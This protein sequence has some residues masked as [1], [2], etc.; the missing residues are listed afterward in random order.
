L[1]SFPARVGPVLPR[2]ARSLPDVPHP[3]LFAEAAAGSD[4]MLAA[5]LAAKHAA[6]N[7]AVRLL[8]CGFI[9]DSASS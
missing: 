5:R 9:S 1:F 2:F 4:A 3:P 6:N 8:A 7:V